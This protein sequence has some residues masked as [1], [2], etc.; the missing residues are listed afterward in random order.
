MKKIKNDS[1]TFQKFQ[2]F[3]MFT[4]IFLSINILFSNC[5]D[6][7]EGCLDIKATNFS[8]SAT[9]QCDDNCCVY[10]NLIVRADYVVDSKKF[11]QDTITLSTN[12]KLK[13]LQVQFYLS[14]FQ[15]FTDKKE[16]YT[17]LDSFSL[18]REKD[19]LRLINNIA[20]LAKTNGFDFNLGSFK[21]TGI[22]KEV[23]FKVGLNDTFKMAVPSKM[24]SSH[25]L[26]TKSDSMY[27]NATK[28]YIFNKIV[29]A[30]GQQFK[31]TVSL[32]ITQA[33]DLSIVKNLSITEGF[34]A[35]IPLKI[36]Y[37]RFF[38]GVTN[39]IDTNRLKQQIVGNYG[40]VFTI[41]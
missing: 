41:Q 21:G 26:S 28:Q 22:F 15:L 34:D 12:E 36:N 16:K 20:L 29:F 30:K 40:M 27:L 7:T 3:G 4:F 37:L 24:P 39:L 32:F 14:D 19:T 13:L 1:T 10:P 18:I 35:V 11:N 8:I 23:R 6:N 25:P 5:Q 31:D 17:P 9:K 2:T 38:D 33:K